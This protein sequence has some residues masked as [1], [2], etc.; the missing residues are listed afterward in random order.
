[1]I[2]QLDKN[3]KAGPEFSGPACILNSIE[4]ENVNLYYGAKHVLKNINL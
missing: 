2:S 1:M 3:Q 4:V